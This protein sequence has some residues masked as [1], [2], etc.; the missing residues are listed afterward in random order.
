M[1]DWSYY[2]LLA[3]RHRLRQTVRW[4]SRGYVDSVTLVGIIPR[5]CFILDVLDLRSLLLLLVIVDAVLGLLSTEHQYI[6]TTLTLA[7]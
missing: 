3:L 5:Y 6:N 4:L 7:L 1:S 2:A